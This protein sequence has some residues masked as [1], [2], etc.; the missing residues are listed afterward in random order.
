MRDFSLKLRLVQLH[1][2]SLRHA[3]T[4]NYVSRQSHP[5]VNTVDR[6]AQCHT[7]PLNVKCTRPS[8]AQPCGVSTQHRWDSLWISDEHTREAEWDIKPGVPVL[9]YC[10]SV[11]TN[12]PTKIF[13]WT[14]CCV[15]NNNYDVRRAFCLIHQKKKCHFCFVKSLYVFQ[16]WILWA[17]RVLW[18]SPL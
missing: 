3:A 18:I 7:T 15:I 12:H 16:R 13:V 6:A 17:R 2:R 9:V 5:H 11:L 1:H 8:A 14:N 10:I 4:A